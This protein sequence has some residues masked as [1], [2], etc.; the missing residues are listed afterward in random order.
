ME[1][2][3]TIIVETLEQG[4]D[5]VM[6]TI[7]DT[8][9][10]T[11]LAGARMLCRRNGSTCGSI[12]GGAFEAEV[13]AAAA[14]IFAADIP[15][16]VTVRHR[17]D[18]NLSPQDSCGSG[19]AAVVEHI[20]AAPRTISIFREL[21]EASNRGFA[22]CL[23]TPLP[24]GNGKE[25]PFVKTTAH[26][27]GTALAAGGPTADFPYPEVISKL[28]SV[29]VPVIEH[30]GNRAFFL[31]PWLIPETVYIC[32]AGHV[33]Q[34]TAELASRSGF[35]VIVMD[36]REKYANSARFPTAQCV[37]ALESFDNC[38]SGMAINDDSYVI[39]ATR[40]HRYEST[41]VR[42]ALKTRAGY[43]GLIGSL[44]KR[45]ALFAELVGEGVGIDDLLRVYCPTGV[46]ILAET[47]Q[48]IAVSIVAQLV[49]LRA[50]K[51]RARKEIPRLP[52]DLLTPHLYQPE[53]EGA[54]GRPIAHRA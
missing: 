43:I 16:I 38:F 47:P 2:L 35:R 17:G 52:G 20:P 3:T 4:E 51:V 42:Q 50:R 45:N 49:L 44:R 30:T 12:G 33:A 15:G 7:A 53:P 14:E 24:D 8:S 27:H 11:R 25:R 6:A 26:L 29:S 40:G 31:N 1:T 13:Q 34:E 19:T 36:D 37:V 9:G 10:H 23:V 46:S 18:E 41:L 48:E 39:I 22:C 5:V 32:G 54:G 28:S 21:L